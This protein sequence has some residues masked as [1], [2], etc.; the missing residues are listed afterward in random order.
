M[1]T[2]VSEGNLLFVDEDYEGAVEKFTEAIQSEPHND[3]TF[4]LR[5]AAHLKLENFTDALSDCSEAIRLN[6]KNAKAY[7]R[8]GWEVF[9]WQKMTF[10]QNRTF[11]AG[12]VSDGKANL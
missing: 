10:F 2:L 1:A 11:F 6:S 7:L 3:E 4:V 8:K 9:L 5:A 12:R